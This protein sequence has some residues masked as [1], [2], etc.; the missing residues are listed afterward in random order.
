MGR[1]NFITSENLENVAGIRHG[2]FTREG[3]VS[4]GLYA[5]LNCGFGSNDDPNDVAT[6]RARV[7]AEM[8]VDP[9]KLLTV[10]QVHSPSVVVVDAPWH[11]EA[12]P[13][14]D[15]MV[16]TRPGIAI[17]I[18]VADCAPV[19]FADP[20]A[21]IVAGA[22]AGWKGA[23]GGVVEATVEAMQAKGADPANIC[24]AVGPCIHQESYE[25]DDGFYRR[26]VDLDPDNA[27][28]FV[29]GQRAGHYQFD[30]PGYVA[31]RIRAAGVG[32]C[33]IVP[34]DTYDDEA[35]Y[36]SFRRATHRKEADYGRNLAV[37]SLEP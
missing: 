11:R 6:N 20:E 13:Q 10:Y 31:G 37:I 25:V 22:H 7:A 1:A 2:F 15:A 23:V 4:T 12:A 36:F 30:L 9:E 14:A 34:A 28:W 29:V 19:L 35:R 26:F 32:S 33:A 17:G 3:G 5:G 18:L 16:C 24:A 8:A 21:G 27:N